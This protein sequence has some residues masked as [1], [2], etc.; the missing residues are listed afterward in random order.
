MQTDMCYYQW[1]S[2]DAYA[3][4]SLKETNFE[5]NSYVQRNCQWCRMRNILL[6][7]SYLPIPFDLSLFGGTA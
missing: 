7:W 4:V 5:S 3:C 1:M 2:G 6:S